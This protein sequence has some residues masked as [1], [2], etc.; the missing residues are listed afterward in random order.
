M[1]GEIVRNKPPDA[2]GNSGELQQMG[3]VLCCW[4]P[5]V[6]LCGWSTSFL[7]G[8][9]HQQFGKFSKHGKQRGF[10]NPSKWLQ[11]PTVSGF[12]FQGWSCMDPTLASSNPWT[13]Q[14]NMDDFPGF[15]QILVGFFLLCFLMTKNS[16]CFMSL[17]FSWHL[18]VS[19]LLLEGYYLYCGISVSL[20]LALQEQKPVSRHH[21]LHHK[22]CQHD[23]FVSHCAFSCHPFL[24]GTGFSNTPLE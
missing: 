6:P 13:K 12:P 22:H 15:Y 17:R 2:L 3:L 8:T 4:E 16:K 23:F 10:K 9:P 20:W 11:L 7:A 24:A 1:H 19:F 5:T 14:W 18:G 21:K